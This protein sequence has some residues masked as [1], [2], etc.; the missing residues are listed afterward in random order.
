MLLTGA[1]LT[2]G[3]APG[4]AALP[5]PW[6][7]QCV[8][9][10]LAVAKFE[11]D[12][13]LLLAEIDASGDPATHLPRMDEKARYAG[14]ALVG[15]CHSLMHEVG[16]RFAREH[17]VTLATLQRYI[18]RSSDPTCSAGF[19]MGLV[20][21]LGPELI[22][23]GGAGALDTCL[24]LPTRYRGYTCVHGIGHALMRGFHGELA[25]AVVRCR[26]LRVYAADCAQ[27]AFH[28]YWIAL[29]GA[30]GTTRLHGVATSPRSVCN[31]H[32]F[33]VRPC[34]YRYFLEQPGRPAAETPADVVRPC[35][36]L[37]PLQR[38]GCVAA[39][40][41]TLAGDPF[42]QLEVCRH[43]RRADAVSCVRGAA[44][45]A[46]AGRPLAQRRLLE[47]CARFAPAARAGC[48]EWLGRTLAVLTDGRS[49]CTA[50]GHARPACERGARRFRDALFTFS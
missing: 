30:D 25:S 40:A 34:W 19:G 37:R 41:V 21:A 16:R 22:R 42:A 10:H 32:L 26:K 23:S 24:D 39:V 8:Q 43:L 47:R 18:P 35:R 50:P 33:Y 20:M 3:A 1:L 5:K 2:V 4:S 44:V 45:Q 36:A 48:Y 15:N 28:D 7:W 6:L 46:V 13:R 31:G 17:G 49:P 29:R 27:G 9:I 14:D 11:C 38:S 12:V